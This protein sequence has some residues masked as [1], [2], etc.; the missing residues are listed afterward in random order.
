MDSSQCNLQTQILDPSSFCSGD[1]KGCWSVRVSTQEHM[2]AFGMYNYL[3]CDSWY[4]DSVYSTD[5][6]GRIMNSKV[7]LVRKK[8]LVLGFSNKFHSQFS[9][10]PCLCTNLQCRH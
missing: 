10:F 8:S 2:H 3:H 7:M 9:F 5:N 4:Q 6:L 1:F